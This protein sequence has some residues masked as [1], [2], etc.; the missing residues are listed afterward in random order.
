[1]IPP[2]GTEVWVERRKWPDLPH[3]G[4]TGLVLGEDEHGVW[5]G[6]RSSVIVAPDGTER[7]GERPAVWCLPRTDWFLIHAW[8]GEDIGRAA[9]DVLDRVRAATAPFAMA[10]ANRWL[11][12]VMQGE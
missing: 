6:A 1:M 5:V 12:L 7:R 8:L 4:V 9:A 10:C 3:Y 2:A 11:D